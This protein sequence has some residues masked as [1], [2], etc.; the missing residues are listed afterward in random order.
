MS[1]APSTHSDVVEVL[2]LGSKPR[3]SSLDLADAIESGLPVTALDRV[4]RFIAPTD[5]SF[6]YRLVSKATLARRRNIRA[7]RSQLS[8]EE[9][10]RLA[11]VALV[12]AVARDVWGDDESARAFLFRAHP[13]LKQRTPIEMAL[14]TDLGARLVEDILGRLRHGSAP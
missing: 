11:R 2:G 1:T 3:K 6:K 12:W 8:P 13:L 14:G 9:S 5:A 10:G 7:H 4:S